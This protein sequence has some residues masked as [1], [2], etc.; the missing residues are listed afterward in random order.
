MAKISEFQW[1]GGMV[2]ECKECPTTFQFA[3]GEPEELEE[4]IKNVVNH[5]HIVDG[6]G[7]S[8]NQRARATGSGVRIMQ[9]GRDMHVTNSVTGSV[10][11][12]LIQAAIV[13]GSIEFPTPK[14]K[15]VRPWGADPKTDPNR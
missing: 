15:F 3:A 5:K 11:G 13:E 14:A 12:G 1:Q 10:H 7:S 6:G 8:I 2:L 4:V 9:S